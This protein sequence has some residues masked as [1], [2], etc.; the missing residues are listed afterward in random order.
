MLT[1]K[2]I[3]QASETAQANKEML[4]PPILFQIVSFTQPRALQMATIICSSH[5][6]NTPFRP[7]KLLCE[8]DLSRQEDLERFEQAYLRSRG[9]PALCAAGYIIVL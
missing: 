3:Q 5:F 2:G 9:V 7:D 6:N 4:E 1:V 8:G